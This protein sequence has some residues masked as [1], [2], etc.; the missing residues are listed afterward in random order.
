M[1]AAV[2]LVVMVGFLVSSGMC[3]GLLSPPLGG[4]PRPHVP[5]VRGLRWLLGG[6]ER[7]RR[8][9]QLGSWQGPLALGLW[10]GVSSVPKA[11][12]E[13]AAHMSTGSGPNGSSSG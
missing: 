4:G 3:R 11:R 1:P 8:R 9:A 10:L 7:E 12:P 6:C 5:N 2:A 13:N